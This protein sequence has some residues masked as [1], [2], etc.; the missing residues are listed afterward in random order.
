MHIPPWPLSARHATA[1][2]GARPR[3]QGMRV[4]QLVDYVNRQWRWLEFFEQGRERR[5]LQGGRDVVRECGGVIPMPAHAI[6][7]ADSTLLTTSLDRTW[8]ATSVLSRT[9]VQRFGVNRSPD[10]SP[11]LMQ[12]WP[13]RSSRVRGWH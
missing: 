11:Y 4:A 12:S 7:H 8:T 2:W 13:A 6:S 5:G 9:N 1:S 3:N 10:L